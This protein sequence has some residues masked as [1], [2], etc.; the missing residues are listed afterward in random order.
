[1]R[2]A[3]AMVAALL[4]AAPALAGFDGLLTAART[5]NLELLKAELAAG[6][7]P[8]PP[9][10]HNGYAPL[11]FAAG[12]GDAGMTRLLLE[13]GADTEYRDHNGDRALLWAAYSGTAETVKL[14]LDAGSPADADADPHGETPMMTASW[15][16]HED[17]V[18]LLLAA[19]ADPNRR[20][21][22]SLTA[23]HLAA[24]TDN[25]AL[26][27]LLL[28]AGA[29]PNVV[30]ESLYETPMHEAAMR[31][32]PAVI[33]VL[34]T[35]HA[36]LEVR[37]HEGMTPL[38]VAAAI[39][40]GANV[41]ALLAA[42]ADPDARRP[43]G[44][45]PILTAL[46]PLNDDRPEKQIGLA[47]L[48]EATVDTDR[49]FA[50]ALG[51][52]RTQIALRLLERGADVNA[53]DGQGRSALANAATQRGMTMYQYLVLR[54]ADVERFGG[55]ALLAAAGAGNS[56]VVR[57]LLGRGFD[58]ETRNADGYTPLLVAVASRRVEMVKLLL[59]A[60]ANRAAR[61]H[62]G[63]GTA[64]L[65]TIAEIPLEMQLEDYEQSAAWHPTEELEINLE[66]LRENRAELHG[67]L[68]L[69]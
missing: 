26:V 33:A 35:A 41:V 66:T 45:T 22:S 9:E 5:E 60:G 18:R 69:D 68:G 32:V 42:S 36:A 46:A 21:Q 64:E 63:R 44:N 57:D 7:D 49:A 34:A 30:S 1:M 61:S 47:A 16:N 55:E 29:N 31:S 38:H 12:N 59:S 51:Y 10:W 43:D 25:A 15:Y 4:S 67:L 2:I 23:L 52:G 6:T 65:L 3:I 56:G 53:L 13:A 11:Q 48:V 14:L 27:Q 19:G 17:M 39:G 40:N 37:D 58:L 24:R 54:G 8:N 20:D 50:A 62:D 28:D